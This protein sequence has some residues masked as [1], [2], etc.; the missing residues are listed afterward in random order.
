MDEL[1]ETNRLL[2][3]E[4]HKVWDKIGSLEEGRH[5]IKGWAITATAAVLA[6][7]VN[8]RR[9]ALILLGLLVAVPMGVVESDYLVR[10]QAFLDRNAELERHLE[11]IRRHGLDAAARAYVFGLGPTVDQRPAGLRWRI[12]FSRRSNAG[13]L[14]LILVVVTVSAAVATGW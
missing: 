2:E 3:L 12:M 6:L 4:Y 1:A 8:A 9:P 11:S 10:Q 14:Y 5:R 7:G 13:Y